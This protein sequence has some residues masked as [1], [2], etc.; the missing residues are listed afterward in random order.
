MSLDFFLILLLRFLKA[1]MK[2]IILF[3]FF[4]FAVSFAFSQ[5]QIRIRGGVLSTNTTVSEY[6]RGFNYFY[7]DSVTLETRRTTPQVNI[8]IDI[9]L[10]KRFFITTGMG[11]SK[12]GLPSVYYNNGGYWYSANQ[13]YMGMIFQLKYHYKFGEERFGV[14]AA[15]GFKADFAIGGPSSAQIATVNGSKY[16]H[17]F[18]TFNQVDFS[19]LTNFGISYHLGPGD[20]VFDVNFQ[21]GLSDIFEDRYIVGRTF[22]VGAS[23]GYS[24]YL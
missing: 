9:D 2:R 5:N 4:C 12:K 20:I 22:S 7:Y 17:A 14:F 16:F 23:L 15:A 6:S 13:E 8:D 3:V 21:N 19:L 1:I 11:Y 18:G 10:G 24:F